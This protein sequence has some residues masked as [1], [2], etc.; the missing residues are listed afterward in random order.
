MPVN[1]SCGQAALM[2]NTREGNRPKPVSFPVRM[3]SSTRAWR[4]CARAVASRRGTSLSIM[5]SSRHAVGSDATGPNN[6]AWSR[7]HL[8]S[9]NPPCGQPK[10][11]G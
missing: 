6:C 4:A 9:I 7:R 10:A 3:R 11:K 8:L 5:D 2:A 1:A